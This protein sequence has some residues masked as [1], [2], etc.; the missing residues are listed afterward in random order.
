MAPIIFSH[1]SFSLFSLPF[2]HYAIIR[3]CCHFFQ[4]YFLHFRWL[5]FTPYYFDAFDY[6]LC[7]YCLPLPLPLI[8]SFQF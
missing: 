2:R 3:H 5:I 6:F 7:D 1:F 4:H 8:F